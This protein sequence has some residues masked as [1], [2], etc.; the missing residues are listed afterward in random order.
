MPLAQC[1]GDRSPKDA[2]TQDCDAAKFSHADMMKTGP[3]HSDKAF[4]SSS[5]GQG[6]VSGHPELVV[7]IGIVW[8]THKGA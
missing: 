6:T 2:G 3:G 8:I 5:G 1:Q 7:R 4:R